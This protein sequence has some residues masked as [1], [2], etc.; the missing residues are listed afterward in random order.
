[1]AHE[2]YVQPNRC[3]Q[4]GVDRL[5]PARVADAV[6]LEKLALKK[7]DALRPYRCRLTHPRNGLV[8]RTYFAAIAA[9][10]KRWPEGMEPQPE[11]NA[12]LLR[13][14]L[15]CKAGRFTRRTAPVA[16]K[17]TVIWLLGEIRDADK[18]AF[19][20][21]VLVD[22]E[23]HLGIF[24]PDSVAYDEM[25]DTEFEPLK[26]A[27]FTRIEEVFGMDVK[28]LIELDATAEA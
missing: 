17:D 26:T 23:P 8:H 11:G 21:E 12:D 27:V 7:S 9:A 16:A 5:I 2:L 20:K 10:A 22:G 4:C 24:V 19:V 25:D 13:A 3:L 6:E 18:Y 15:Q 1:M 28:T 14:W